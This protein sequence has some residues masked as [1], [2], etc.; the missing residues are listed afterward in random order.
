[1]PHS[2]LEQKDISKKTGRIW[3][4]FSVN[5]VT[6]I[7]IFLINMSWLCKRL[8]EEAGWWVYKKRLHYLCNSI[9]VKL[10]QNKKLKKLAVIV[11]SH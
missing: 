9:H 6:T 3:E 5:S 8:T 7:L 11:T 4:K 2:I 1:M 10:F